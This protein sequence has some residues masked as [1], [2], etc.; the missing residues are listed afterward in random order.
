M[1]CAYATNV[2]LSER[3]AHARLQV[4]P[5]SL[6]LACLAGESSKLTE[7]TV[8]NMSDF[9]SLVRIR[10]KRAWQYCGTLEL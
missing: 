3:T 5:A 2:H 10:M 6:S 1:L 4:L 8:T 7:V 9:S